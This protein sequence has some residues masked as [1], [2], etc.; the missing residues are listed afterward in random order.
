[1]VGPDLAALT[2]RSPQALM[3]AMLDPN[4]AV[5]AKFLEFTAFTTDGRQSA[6]ILTRETTTDLTLSA[7]EGK[8][9]VILRKDIELLRS[10]GKSL[11]P[12][13]LEKD[14][15]HQDFA[16]LIGYLRSQGPPPKSFPGNT[17]LLVHPNEKDQVLELTAKNCRIYGPAIQFEQTYANLG[18]W[19]GAED[20]AEWTFQLPAAGKYQVWLDFACDQATAGNRFQLGYAGGTLKGTIPSTGTWD[21][22]Q[23]KMIGTISLSAGTN[24]LAFHAD[25]EPGGFLVDLRAIKLIPLR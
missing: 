4:R 22:Y 16:D 3:T 15:S 1:M 25:G 20:R 2:D 9:F 10:T 13:G 23:Q 7:P 8:Q 18:F 11:M 21:N 14:I 19:R 24:D 6:G 5:E 12:V 17:P